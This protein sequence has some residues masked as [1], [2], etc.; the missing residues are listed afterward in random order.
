LTMSNDKHRLKELETKPYLTSPDS[1][2]SKLQM[3]GPGSRVCDT[4]EALLLSHRVL[5]DRGSVV[6]TSAD[7]ASVVGAYSHAQEEHQSNAY[8]QLCDEV[9][10]L[11]GQMHRHIASGGGHQEDGGSPLV[12]DMKR[13]REIQPILVQ[14]REIGRHLELLCERTLYQESQIEQERVRCIKLSMLSTYLS[15]SWHLLNRVWTHI[16]CAL[17][18]WHL[19]SKTTD[20]MLSGKRMHSKNS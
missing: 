12:V 1:A 14:V 16:S 15:Q 7:R 20:L 17:R 9:C 2:S 5:S 4:P 8:S 10:K 6:A 18:S 19:V 11:I 3:T 13:E